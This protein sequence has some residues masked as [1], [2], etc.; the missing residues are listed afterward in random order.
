MNKNTARKEAKRL[1]AKR[2]ARKA[3]LQWALVIGVPLVIIGGLI[4]FSVIEAIPKDGDTGSRT[5]DLPAL[6]NDPDGDGRITLAEFEGQPVVLNFYADWCIACEREL[7]AFAA[8]AE[9]FGDR[10]HFVHVNSQETGSWQRLVEEFGTDTWPIARDI[11]GTVGNGSGLWQ[12]LGGR[13][14][15]ITAFYDSAGQLVN[16]NNGAM[17]ESNLRAILVSEFGIS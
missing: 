12:S 13:G 17:N 9:A 2:A 14:M 8:A 4:L 7:P 10:V 5:W 15:P 6:A 3:K 1:A 16:V 11:N